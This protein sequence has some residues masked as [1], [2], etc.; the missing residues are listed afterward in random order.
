ML[1]DLFEAGP[2]TLVNT[3][4]GVRHRLPQHTIVQPRERR[5][6]TEFVE[7]FLGADITDLACQD[8]KVS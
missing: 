6:R 3:S 4:D 7:N 2:S 5:Q 8:I 1:N